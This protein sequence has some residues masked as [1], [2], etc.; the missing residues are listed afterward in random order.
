MRLEWMNSRT[1]QGSKHTLRTILG[2]SANVGRVLAQALILAAV[3]VW[4]FG[5][6]PAY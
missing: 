3:L 4:L 6:R 2:T 5:V 1:R